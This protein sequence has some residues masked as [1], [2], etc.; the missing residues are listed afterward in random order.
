MNF[1]PFRRQAKPTTD[2]ASDPTS[3]RQSITDELASIEDKGGFS[4][5]PGIARAASRVQIA[6]ILGAVP[7]AL[8]AGVCAIPFG[9]SVAPIAA[10]S[11]FIIAIGMSTL[12][13]PIAGVIISQTW[14][15]SK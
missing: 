5:T 10:F 6:I 7:A 13:I 14:R 9:W 3:P 15:S 12:G 1:L 4:M 11:V 8:V 2:P